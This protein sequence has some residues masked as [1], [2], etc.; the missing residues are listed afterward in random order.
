MNL[1]EKSRQAFEDQI[2]FSRNRF[3][4]CFL[5]YILSLFF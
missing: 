2:L 1:I 4:Y 3:A 5:N